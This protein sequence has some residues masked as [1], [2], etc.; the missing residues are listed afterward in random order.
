MVYYVI[1]RKNKGIAFSFSFSIVGSVIFSP[2][3]SFALFVFMFVLGHFI[4]PGR[5]TQTLSIAAKHG[6]YPYIVFTLIA[7]IYPFWCVCVCRKV[8]GNGC[9]RYTPHQYGKFYFPPVHKY[10]RS[11]SISTFFATNRL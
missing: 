6:H 2:F 9:P 4:A 8:L 10:F 11:V 1:K 7:L 5:L 3:S